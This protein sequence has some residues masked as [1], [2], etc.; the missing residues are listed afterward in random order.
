V[1]VLR[2]CFMMLVVVSLL[3]GVAAGFCV[4]EER[5]K[6]ATMNF[7]LAIFAAFVAAFFNFLMSLK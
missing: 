3:A 5:Y 2:I 6:E 7:R 1:I 4:L